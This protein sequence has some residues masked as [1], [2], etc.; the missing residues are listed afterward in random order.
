MNM[1][2]NPRRPHFP[3]DDPE[4]GTRNLLYLLV[5]MMVVQ[6]VLSV[7]LWIDRGHSNKPSEPAGYAETVQPGEEPTIQ[8]SE[9]APSSGGTA[10]SYGG[11]ETVS[12]AL[13]V[14]ILNGCNVPGIARKA[15]DWLV[16]NGYDVRDVGNADRND[17]RESKVID[18][19][20]NVEAA[21]EL[22]RLAGIPESRVVRLNGSPSPKLDL[23]LVLGSDY[24]K[25]AFAR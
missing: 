24:R 9:S 11:S 2:P 25:L 8:A 1:S 18:R 3:E 21:K 4:R 13:R 16:R 15:G 23:S 7:G 12:T 17:Y 20:G 19:G 14:Q 5:G 6:L 10:E 22:A